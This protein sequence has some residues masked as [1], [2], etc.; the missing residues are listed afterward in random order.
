MNAKRLDQ[1][2]RAR[3]NRRWAA[4]LGDLPAALAF[5]LPAFL[6]A[7]VA[8]CLFACLLAGLLASCASRSQ[9]ATTTPIARVPGEAPIANVPAADSMMAG[10]LAAARAARLDPED[11]LALGAG[12]PQVLGSGILFTYADRSVRTVYV[13]GTFNGWVPNQ[14]ELARRRAADSLWVGFVPLPSRGR[15]LYK[16]LADGRRWVVDPANPER[17]GDGA[18]G[19]AS[20]VVVP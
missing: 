15:H 5:P 16:F 4:P 2:G 10:A 7:L 19:V 17:A 6:L 20:V 9:P 14:H 13:A 18:G 1:A 8:S 12:P 11:L 3:R